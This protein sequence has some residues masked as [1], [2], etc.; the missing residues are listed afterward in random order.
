MNR[1]DA[2]ELRLDL[3]N[4]LWRADRDDGYAAAVAS[5]IG[6]SHRQA[7]DIVAPARE[8][9]DDARQDASF[10]IDDD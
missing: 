4:H 10:V 3:L 6:L 7:F 1:H 9:A 8:K 5:V 2:V